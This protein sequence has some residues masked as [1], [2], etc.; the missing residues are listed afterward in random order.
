MI[1]LPILIEVFI[2]LFI[3]QV[4][5]LIVTTEG[6]SI[7][8]FPENSKNTQTQIIPIIEFNR[9]FHLRRQVLNFY[10]VDFTM[11]YSCNL[12]KGNETSSCCTMYES[13]ENE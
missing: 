9:P 13:L 2:Q 10:Y 3:L 12:C 5:Y 7:K 11:F 8:L 1:V 6:K 4:E